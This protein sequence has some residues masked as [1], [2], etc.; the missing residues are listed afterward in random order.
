MNKR[1]RKKHPRERSDKQRCNDC[2]AVFNEELQICPNCGRDDC[3]MHPFT[4]NDA[5]WDFE[6][7][8]YQSK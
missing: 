2:C 8:S 1:Q 4:P 3:L 7:Y 5:D 6:L